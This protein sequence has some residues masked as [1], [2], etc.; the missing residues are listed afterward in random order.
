MKNESL[1][2]A[3]KAGFPVGAV[4]FG[5]LVGPAMVTGS[6]TINYFLCSGVKGWIYFF[7][8]AAAIGWFFFMGFEHTRQTAL[9]NPGVDVYSYTV[10]SRSL[11]GPKLRF[12]VP[13]YNLWVFVAMIITGATTVATGGTLIA[14]FLGVDYIIGAIIMALLNMCIAV[15]GVEMIRKSS[16][17]MTFGIIAM[18]VV[19]VVITVATKGRELVEFLGSDWYPPTGGRSWGNGAW[20]VFVLTCSSCSWALGLGAV[21]Q[22]MQTKKACAAGGLSAG[23]LGAFAFFLMYIIVVPWVN[24]TYAG[25]TPVEAPVLNIATD[26]LGMPWLGVIY[27]VLMILALVSSG[28]PSLFVAADRI[29]AIIPPARNAKNQTVAMIGCCLIYSVVVVIMAT[30]GLTT[31]VSYYFQ[32]LGYFGQICGVI[33][34]AIVWPILRAKGVKPIIPAPLKSSSGQQ[35]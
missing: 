6:Y 34:M 13:I 30:G 18:M 10:L 11:Y 31:I 24:E 12:M 27:Y 29:K 17:Y 28:A 22:K 5:A 8:Y 19:L 15:F 20:R 9:C 16:T 21:A 7:I 35:K 4:F 33:P 1:W 32:Y 2:S 26:W 25:G 23:I 3:I 14:S